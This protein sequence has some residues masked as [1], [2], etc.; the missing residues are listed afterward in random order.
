MA[1]QSRVSIVAAALIVQ[2]TTEIDATARALREQGA[3]Y[4]TCPRASAVAVT[5]VGKLKRE[6]PEA[7]SVAL[8][9]LVTP[10]SLDYW[11]ALFASDDR[12]AEVIKALE[13][14]RTMYPRVRPQ[15]DGSLEITLA[16]VH[17]EHEDPLVAS[18][19]MVLQHPVILRLVENPDDWR[20]ERIG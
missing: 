8:D 20:V 9:E 7:E 14:Y 10:E 6:D 13:F 12:R 18:P 11:S 19:R 15:A 2:R 4:E 16:W 1:A 5:F 3:T 17:P